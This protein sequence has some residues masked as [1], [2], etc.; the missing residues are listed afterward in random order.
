MPR[1]PIAHFGTI[2][3]YAWTF[4]DGTTATTTAATLTHTYAAA[5][6]YPVT[7]TVTDSTGTST[8]QVF[9]GQTMSR[10]GG[11]SATTT[12]AVTILVA[13]SKGYDLVAADGGVFNFNLGFFGSAGSI[14]LNKPV[15]GM[16]ATPDGKGYWL[17]ASDGGIFTYGDAGFFGSAGHP[18]ERAHRGHGGHARRKGLL[19]GGLRRR[20][21]HLRRRRLLRLG[22][23]P[24][25]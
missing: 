19:A 8:T 17:V 16:A 10:N 6:S 14:H 25:T 9:T 21:L 1:P 3:S 22:R 12:H 4:G 15:V 18:P 11:P 13:G 20:H 23:R 2:A 7:L 24:S 5:G